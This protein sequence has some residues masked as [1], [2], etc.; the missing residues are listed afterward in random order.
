MR[1]GAWP[2]GGC[3]RA[4]RRAGCRQGPCD[5]VCAAAR[6]ARWRRQQIKT[7]ATTT[8][9]LLQLRAWLVEQVTVAGIEAT[10]DYWK[11]VCYLLEEAVEVQLLNAVHMPNV[12]GGK[13]DVTDAA[14]IARLTEHGLVRPSFVPPPPIRRLR[15]LTRCHAALIAE[16]TR[17]KQRMEKLLADAGIKVSMF[18]WSTGNAIRRCWPDTPGAG[19]GRRYRPGT[20]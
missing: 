11:P 17:E 19:S 16:R 8:G 5:G 15:D 7:L 13:T 2:G 10:G 6:A 1:E 4:V 3:D 12:P 9:G 20:V 14:W 18:V